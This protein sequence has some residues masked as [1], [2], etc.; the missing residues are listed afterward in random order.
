MA[1]VFL[2]ILN[3]KRLITTDMLIL[4]IKICTPGCQKV[5]ERDYN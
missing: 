5:A 2:S 4:S 1:D 3:L